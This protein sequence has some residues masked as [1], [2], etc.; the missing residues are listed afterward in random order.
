[1]TIAAILAEITKQTADT[2]AETGMEFDWPD[3]VVCVVG[4]TILA[5]WLL[6]TRLGKDALIDSKPR[7][8]MLPIWALV[9]VFLLWTGIVLI[10]MPLLSVIFD[11]MGHTQKKISDTILV[12]AAHIA[13]TLLAIYFARKF[14]S[15]GLKGF[16]FDLRTIPRDMPIAIINLL[17]VLPLV[18]AALLIIVQIGKMTSGPDYHVP[19][20]QELQNI[21]QST[22]ASLHILIVISTIFVVPIF[23]E[24]FFRGLIQTTIKSFVKKPWISITAASLIFVSF[25][26]DLAHWPALLVLGM[27]MGYAYEKSGSLWRAIFI[28]ATFNAMGTIATLFA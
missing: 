4:V 3:I 28:H 14:F 11:D 8:N 5:A 21:Q 23:E 20:H 24:I 15:R 16:G 18:F 7:R 2:A 25:H 22:N 19:Q 6:R 13:G 17:A 12:I 1:M 26:A 9:V 10:G 27:C